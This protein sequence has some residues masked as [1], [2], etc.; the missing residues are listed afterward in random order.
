MKQCLIMIL[1]VLFS[2]P[3]LAA[4]THAHGV[5]GK[6]FIPSTL[7][8]ED[9]FPS[10]EMDLFTFDRA[11]KDKEGRETSFGFE[12]AK[13]LTPDLAIGVG[14]EYIFFDPRE[15]GE[16]R[17]S[18]AGT[19]EFSVK[20]AFLRSIAHEAILS[21]G[22][23]VEAGGVSSKRVAKR[24]TTISPALYFGKGL[25]DL[26]ASLTYFK[27][28]SL[29]GSFAVNN[30]A[31]RFTGS[32]ED[33]ERNPTTLSYGVALMYSIP[34]LQSNIKD[35]GLSAPL[36]RMFPVVEF[37]FETPVSGPE[38]RRTSAFANPGL[39]WAGKY[40]QLG[41]EAQVPMNKFSGKNV[42]VKGLIHLFIDDIW[43]N[44]FTWT[45]W[46]VIGPTSK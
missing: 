17:T 13:R 38:K 42:G 9:P 1:S 20:Y 18:G 31:N 29:N 19:P 11:P 40:V 15:R 8:I 39:I 10:D 43:P 44:V 30:P 4:N 23:E 26:P 22:L 5:I 24:V 21:A 28:F 45:P 2:V 3:I 25:G 41:V 35:V 33:K 37:N 34:Y 36:D 14:W 16:G 32:G 27:P 6:R 7:T 46:G 12:F